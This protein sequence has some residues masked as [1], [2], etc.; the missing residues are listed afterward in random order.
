M[1][2]AFVN[3]TAIIIVIFG[4]LQIILFFKV[5]IMTDDVKRIKKN[6]IDG[7]DASFETAKKELLIGN[8]DKA[9]EIYN[10]CFIN[11]IAAIYYETKTENLNS[12]PAKDTY[13]IKYKKTCQRYE[14][15]IEKLGTNCPIDFSRFDNFDKVDKIMS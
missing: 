5:W 6:L 14:K 11:E 13:E 2:T 9:I 3:F 8:T 12:S 7:T 4:I 15:E 1:G 10:K